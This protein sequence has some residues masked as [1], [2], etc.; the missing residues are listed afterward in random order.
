MS[1]IPP[2]DRLTKAPALG[3][4]KIQQ[5]FNKILDSIVDQANKTIKDSAKL[6]TNV[7]CD[8]PRVKKHK[9]KFRKYTI[10]N[11]KSSRKYS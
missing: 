4:D 1:V 9:T 3:V 8:D 6:P 10:I 2:L 5:Q 11:Y 7:N